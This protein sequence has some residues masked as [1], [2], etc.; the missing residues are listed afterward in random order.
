MKRVQQWAALGVCLCFFL[1][2]EA[3]GEVGW[4]A[5][6]LLQADGGRYS[7]LEAGP[8]GTLHLAFYEYVNKD[9]RYGIRSAAGEWTFETVDTTG[10]VGWFASLELDQDGVPRIAYCEF[11]D[12]KLKY[13]VRRGEDDWAVETVDSHPGRGWYS[14][15]AL[16]SAGN[17][18]IAYSGNRQWDLMHAWCAPGAG[19]Q[20]ETIDS[21]GDVG[22]Y[23]AL[24][25]D[26]SDLGRISY[27]DKSDRRMK[28]A[29]Q[30]PGGAWTTEVVDDSGDAGL[31][32]VL[33]LDGD[34]HPHVAY[35][36]RGSDALKYAWHDGADWRTEIVEAGA[37]CGYEASIVWADGP[38]ISYEGTLGVRYARKVAGVWR[39]DQVDHSGD[40]CGDTALAL[41]G[42]GD[43]RI[44]YLNLGDGGLYYAEGAAVPLPLGDMDG[45]GAVNNNDIAPFALALTDRAAYEATYPGIDPDIVGDIDASG[46]LNNN[47]IAPFVTLLTGPPQTAPE[48]ATLALL[49]LGGLALL[50]RRSR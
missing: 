14:S 48:P 28:F 34:G 50:R 11:D 35:W 26:E 39:I 22:Q 36:D 5:P 47:D 27:F 2:A 1:R 43:P 19:W 41:E 33:A 17:P 10:D 3:F 30:Q 25:L 46:D 13:A 38:H 12:F 40:K 49:A 9:L 37:D 6:T 45:S 7:S 16:D 15:L 31:D 23:C 18:H 8:D 29:W 24:V 32:T 42:E 21:A 4:S 44:A 20:F